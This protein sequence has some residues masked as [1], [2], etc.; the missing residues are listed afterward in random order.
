[1]RSLAADLGEARG[2][3]MVTTPMAAHI[4]LIHTAAMGTLIA[5]PTSSSDTAT[6]DTV[7]LAV[8]MEDTAMVVDTAEA[9]MG[10]V[11]TGVMV[12]VTNAMA[13]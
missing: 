6:E 12:V 13:T 9:A 1:M 3:A 10:A 4:I 8:I 11:D 2:V 7:P 5:T